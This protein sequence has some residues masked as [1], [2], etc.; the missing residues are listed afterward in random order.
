MRG[1][2]PASRQR[3]GE[4]G[5]TPP[6]RQRHGSGSAPPVALNI[7]KLPG[8]RGQTSSLNFSQFE[9]DQSGR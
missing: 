9:G 6:A 7:A 5:G 8:L 1:T 2:V 3:V 4:P